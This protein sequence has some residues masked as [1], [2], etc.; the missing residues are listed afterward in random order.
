[1]GLA[2]RNVHFS[3]HPGTPL[4]R[5]VLR[6]VDLEIREGE[7]LFLL[8]PSGCGKSTL[9]LVAAGLL[10]PQRGTLLLDGKPCD[11]AGG[12][13]AR[14]RQ[15][16]GLL[17]QSPEDQLFADTVEADVAFG[18]RR[19]GL[20]PRE[21]K[22]KTAAALR[23]VG[24]EPSLYFPLSPFGLS[25]G[26]MRRVAL[27]GVLVREP[28]LLFLDE[29]FSGLDGEGRKRLAA[30]LRELRGA[31]AGI[32]FVTHEWEEV[33]L[34]A[35]RAAVLFEGRLLLQGKKE[36]VLGDREGLRRAGLEPPPRVE[37]LH[38]LRS[39]CPSLPPYARD[40]K[41]AAEKID[42][43]MRGDRG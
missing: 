11:G 15:E 16:V 33:D 31:G 21:V 6:G 22:E 39:R 7:I 42:A 30:L 18:L 41:E 9:L 19:A 23:S 43:L 17:L 36:R 1:M 14:L 38:R 13:R 4:A 28:R 32:L 2:L 24:L 3:Y 29:P 35:D 27:A 12:A 40:A 25:R 34:L 37:L 20:S 5:E 8:G 26:E 10:T